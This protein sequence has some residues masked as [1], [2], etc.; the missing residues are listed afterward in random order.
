M[1]FCWILLHAN[2]RAANGLSLVST[3]TT[4]VNTCTPTSRRQWLHSVRSS[5]GS[6]LCTLALLQTPKDAMA[7]TASSTM[8]EEQ[9]PSTS[10]LRRPTAPI[11]FLIPAAQIKLR[12][13]TSLQLLTASA[14][15]TSEKIRQLLYLW[16]E[17]PFLDVK[18][19]L[20]AHSPSAAAA[21]TSP[22]QQQ[23]AQPAP[24]YEDRYT[25]NRQQLSLWQQ[26]GAFLVQRGEVSA[27]QRLVRQEQSRSQTNPLRAAFNLYTDALVFSSQQYV[28]T[29]DAREKSNRIRNDQLPTV[30]SVVTAD[31]DLR[32][33]Y[34]NQILTCI[35]DLRAELQSI[36]DNNDDELEEVQRILRE[37]NGAMET[38]L[39]FIEPEE[40]KM[41]LQGAQQAED[42]WNVQR[43]QL[44]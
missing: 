1:V 39:G 11:E 13:D 19:L 36:S 5:G 37:A 9:P 22:Q 44:Q 18:L 32:A 38:W 23:P 21:T 2:I 20:L 6:L 25:Q 30:T 27:W 43:Q 4:T 24:S 28:L 16:N 8:Q 35:D 26:P 12:I 29:V 42:A 17:R 33:L 15:T 31:L 3:S 40:V 7:A 41:A 10:A 14:P 34:R